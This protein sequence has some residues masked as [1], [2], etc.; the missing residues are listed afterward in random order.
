[1]LATAPVQEAVERPW[2]VGD[3][4]YEWLGRVVHLLVRDADWVFAGERRPPAD[5]L[6]HHDAE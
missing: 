6:V 1:M 4:L 3:E 5:H 2:H